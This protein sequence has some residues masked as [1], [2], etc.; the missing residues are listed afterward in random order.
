MTA[1][2]QAENGDT[3]RAISILTKKHQDAKIPKCLSGAPHEALQPAGVA[4]LAD[5]PD[6]GSG[7]LVAWEFKSLRPHHAYERE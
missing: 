4:E 5:A 1:N 7:A 6:L 3:I 2:K